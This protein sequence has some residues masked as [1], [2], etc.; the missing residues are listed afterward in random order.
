M[1]K[2][3]KRLGFL[4][5]SSLFLALDH[6]NN[7]SGTDTFPKGEHGKALGR[8]GKKIFILK[9]NDRSRSGSHGE[10]G[11]GRAS[12]SHGKPERL[13]AGGLVEAP[14]ALRLVGIVKHLPLNILDTVDFSKRRSRRKD[15]DR[16]EED[17]IGETTAPSTT[18]ESATVT[19]T[20]WIPSVAT[21]VDQRNSKRNSSQKRKSTT[22]PPPESKGTTV[23]CCKQ[24][25][26]FGSDDMSESALRKETARMN[27]DVLRRLASMLGEEREKLAAEREMM[28]ASRDVMQAETRKVNSERSKIEA[29]RQK[30][31]LERDLLQSQMLGRKIRSGF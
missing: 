21:T 31:D 9:E 15:P 6:V 28:T 8:Y 18:T 1:Y 7:L 12:S 16:P 29:E 17:E 4:F 26:K 22:P 27:L 2:T 20:P 5:S 14:T 30:L 13:M 25:H 23:S 3:W 10:V 19:P 24:H 11:E